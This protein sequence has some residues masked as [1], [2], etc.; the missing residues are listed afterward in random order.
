MWYGFK[1]YVPVAERKLRARRALA[2]LQKALGAAPVV[3]VGRAIAHTFWGRA[4][5]DNLE[6]YSDFANRL[7]RGRT[8]VRHGYVVDLQVEQ[9]EVTAK[10]S[11][12]RLY[13]V[14]VRVTALSAKRWKALCSDCSGAI[15][16]LIELLQGHFSK[17]VMTRVCQPR[18]GLFPEPQEIQFACSCPDWAS[19][20]KHVAAVLYGIGARLDERPEL[21][22]TLRGVDQTQLV[23]AAGRGLPAG[24]RSPAK[25]RVLADDNLS[26][27]FG[28]DLGDGAA[29]P[30]ARPRRRATPHEPAA[31][32]TPTKRTGRAAQRKTA[33]KARSK[34]KKTATGKS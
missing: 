2:T 23:A 18:E 17:A 10:V 24:R 15:D 26:E 29:Q 8:Y 4:W 11:G 1:P 12:S 28:L 25:G 32:T 16:S 14:S 34:T 7:P 20:C 5:C 6:R 27:L 31:R 3:I 19:M 9:G 22:F 30:V 33:S 21:L 13:D